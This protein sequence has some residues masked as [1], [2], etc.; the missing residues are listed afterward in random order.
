M[1]IVVSLAAIS[2]TVLV[3]LFSR[4]F[5]QKY[6]YP[7]TLPLLIATIILISLLLL[8]QIPYE[9]YYIGGQWLEKLLGP[10]VVALAYPLYR[11]FDMLKRHFKA[12]IVGVGTGAVVGISSGLFLLKWIGFDQTVVFSLVPKSVTTP[13]A[14]DVATTLGGIGALAAI[15]VMVAGIFGVV[16]GPYF[17]K[18]FNITSELSKGIATGSASHAIGTAKALENSEAEGAAS[19]VAMTLSAII[20]SII[21]PILVFLFY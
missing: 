14:M 15:N 5:Y 13:V 3:Y 10:A 12:I 11:Q 1:M 8:F 4:A 20:V 18:W 21:A 9:T 17:F 2:V 19:S 7:F 16:L 6:S